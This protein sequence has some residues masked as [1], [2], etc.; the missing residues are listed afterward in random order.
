MISYYKYYFEFKNRL[1]LLFFTWFS[2]LLISYIYK[3]EVL[4]ILIIPI[5]YLNLV[6]NQH[7]SFIFTSVNEMFNVYMQL[8]FFVANQFIVLMLLYHTLTF[9][10][11]GLYKYEFITFKM[12]LQFFLLSWLISLL[13]LY[14]FLIPVSWSFFLSFQHLKTD[15]QLVSFFFESKII[16]YLDYFRNFYYISLINC[17]FFTILIFILIN[18]QEKSNKLKRFR[19]LFYFVFVLFS[20]LITP[21]DIISQMFLSI[22]LILTYESLIFLKCLKIS[23]ATN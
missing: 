17:H 6:N 12:T 5:N 15:F 14:N 2:T 7:Y 13:L 10:S 23:L 22:I 8:I 9:L 20:T 21:P 3:E 4:F 19:K 18:I 11:F 1:F 16:E